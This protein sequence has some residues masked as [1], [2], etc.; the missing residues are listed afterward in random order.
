MRYPSIIK[1]LAYHIYNR[2]IVDRII[3]KDSADYNFFILRLQQYKKR[4]K[5]ELISFC[6]M[7]NHFHIIVRS[8]HSADRI[9]K[10]MKSWQQSYARR[11]NKKYDKYGHVFQGKYQHKPIK[12]NLDLARVIKYIAQNP[13]KKGLARRAEEW[14]YSG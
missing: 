13:V 3:F 6:I 10:F 4:F 11:F 14:P 8:D 12:S 7:P 5:L 1:N 9:A 2:A